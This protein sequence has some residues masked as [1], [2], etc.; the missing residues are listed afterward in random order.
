MREAYNHW[1][2]ATV[3]SSVPEAIRELYAQD[4]SSVSGAAMRPEVVMVAA[5]GGADDDLGAIHDDFASGPRAFKFASAMKEER[6][7]SLSG[8]STPPAMTVDVAFVIDVTGSMAPYLKAVKSNMRSIITLLPAG[9][10]NMPQFGH[11]KLQMLVA[12]VPFRDYDDAPIVPLG[13]GAWNVSKTEEQNNAIQ[14]KALSDYTDELVAVGGG[15][16]AEDSLGALVKCCSLKWSSTVKFAVLI[17]DAPGHG[18]ECNSFTDPAKDRCVPSARA[19]VQTSVSDAADALRDKEITLLVCHIK[20]DSGSGG[21]TQM[22]HDSLKVALA[23]SIAA[24]KQTTDVERALKQVT[25]F[26]GAVPAGKEIKRMHYIF[27]LDGS[28]SMSGAPWA[29]VI[30]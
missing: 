19:A 10:A 23:R 27:V 1:V 15:D 6:E 29:G 11:I 9:V 21:G 24:K 8:G 7:L 28:G 13:F 26:N 22:M 17:T 30:E 14:S 16:L 25:L 4:E 3:P 18:A 20:K 5:G 2:T 12:C